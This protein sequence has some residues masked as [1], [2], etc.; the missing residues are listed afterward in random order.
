MEE[1]EKSAMRLYV[2]SLHFDVTEADL[3]PV[4]EVFGAVDFIDLHKDPATGTSRGFGF[5][6][7]KNEG[8][9]KQALQA[10]NGIEIA[11]R[12]IKVGIVENKQE[13]S[14]PV[15]KLDELDESDTGGFAMTAQ[16]RAQLM[17]KLQR[18]A[19]FLNPGVPLLGQGHMGGSGNTSSGVISAQSLPVPMIQPTTCVIVKNMFDPKSPE[20]E[21]EWWFD[22]KEDVEE[23]CAKHGSLKHIV[24]D[25]ETPGGH[26]YLRF[27]NVATAEKVVKA[28]HGRWYASRQ[29]SA[30]FVVEAT[31]LLKFPEAK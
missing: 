30:E 31:Y 8:D 2:G 17:L 21:S 5:V 9:A 18:G 22:I 6:Q 28:F 4:F 26:V 14:G 12:A 11:G 10:L 20:N 27:H 16:S 23:E 7:Y 29:V 25:R 13:N 3:R 19:P 15:G 24:V 1:T